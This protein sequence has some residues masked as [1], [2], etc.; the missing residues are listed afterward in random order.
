MYSNVEKVIVNYISNLNVIQSMMMQRHIDR[1]EIYL[2][3]GSNK[4]FKL[5]D[6]ISLYFSKD[7]FNQEMTNN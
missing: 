4:E 1:M 5:F 6:M 7:L 3:K 2:Y